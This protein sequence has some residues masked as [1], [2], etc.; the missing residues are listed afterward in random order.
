MRPASS[1]PWLRLFCAGFAAAWLLSACGATREDDY[2]TD[3][4]KKAQYEYG[5]AIS[6]KGGITLFGD[7]DDNRKKGLATGIGVNGFL[8]RAALDTISFMPI[9][10][11][12][13]F[14]GTIITDWYA[15]PS[16][17]NERLRL[18]VFILGRELRADGIKVNVFR[19]A[20]SSTGWEDAPTAAATAGSVEDAILTR[21]R[22]LH[23]KQLEEQRKD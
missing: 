8:W 10:S 19:Q 4:A 1:A 3:K 15:P 6:D 16:S 13:P 20:R 7:R 22:Q 11:A 18:N 21:A 23:I 12:D 17:P 9:A 2:N 5:S 14:G